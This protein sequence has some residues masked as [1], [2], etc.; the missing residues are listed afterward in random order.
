[1]D[2]L[3]LDMSFEEVGVMGKDQLKILLNDQVAKCAFK[4]LNSEKSKLSKMTSNSYDRLEIQPYLTDPQ[5]S[6]RL[7]QLTF[8]WRTRMVPVGWNFGQKVPCPL[9][10]AEDDTQNHL[11]HCHF[12]SDDCHN[13][14]TDSNI[15]NNNYNLKQHMKRLENAIRKR[16]IA[17]E[18]KSEQNAIP[19]NDIL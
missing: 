6:I 5:L 14:M 8:K 15:N 11:F 3:G 12:I 18:R 7:K 1:M 16:E 10:K 13:D 2:S 9:C 17:L 4:D 19:P